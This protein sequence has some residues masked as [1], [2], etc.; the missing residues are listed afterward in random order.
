MRP[1]APVSAL[2]AGLL[3]LLSSVAG[4]LRAQ[5][6]PFHTS[7]GVTA[8]FQENAARG[9]VTVLGRSGHLR[10]GREVTDPM[11]RDVDALGVVGGAILGGFTPYW[12]YR[13]IVPWMRKSMDF[14]TSDGVRRHFDASG[15]G[16]AILQSKWIF[17]R[18][19]RLRGTTRVGIRGRLTVPLGETEAKLPGGE[20]AP[21]PLQVGNGSWDFEPTAVFTWTQGRWGVHANTGW[22]FNTADGGFEAGDVLGYDAAVGL[23][24]LPRVYQSLTDPTLGAYLELNGRVAGE[25]EVA[26]TEN[27]DSGGHLLFLSPDLQWI[28]TP[29]LLFEGS[30]QVPVVQGLNGVQLEHEI[31]FQLGSRVRFSV[32]R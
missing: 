3:L 5:A 26:G 15:V 32:F 14:T 2:A 4:S 6:L 20:V 23:R 10:D 17:L 25:V 8:G 1:Q 13:V 31:R 7:T 30:V 12:T 27:P 29:W 18:E 24:L 9:F 22:R 11:D 28:P 16:D 21:R 19:N